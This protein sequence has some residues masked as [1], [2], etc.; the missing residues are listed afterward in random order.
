[1]VYLSDQDGAE[2]SPNSVAAENLHRL[3]SFLGKTLQPSS[4]EVYRTFSEMM[5]QHP[6]ALPEMVCAFIHHNQTP[7]QVHS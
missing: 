1:M 6:V 2:P 7:K 5:S 3:S 4:A